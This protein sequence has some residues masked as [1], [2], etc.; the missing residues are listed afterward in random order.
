MQS[1]NRTTAWFPRSDSHPRGHPS[2]SNNCAAS[3]R[4]TAPASLVSL[5]ESTAVRFQGLLSCD[6]AEAPGSAPAM[7]THDGTISF[8]A[9]AYEFS[10]TRREVV[11]IFAM[12]TELEQ[13]EVEASTQTVHYAALSS[14][15]AQQAAAISTMGGAVDGIVSTAVHDALGGG[16]PAPEDACVSLGDAESPETRR[17]GPEYYNEETS[18]CELLAYPCRDGEWESQRAS[19]TSNRNCREWTAC[20]D[21]QFE[22]FAPS[23]TQDRECRDLT[24]ECSGTTPHEFVAPTPTSDRV[25]TDQPPYHGAR[26]KPGKS[27]KFLKDERPDDWAES[28]FYWVQSDQQGSPTRVYCDMVSGG[29]RWH[30]LH[31]H[32]ITHAAP[33]HANPST[34]PRT[35]TPGAPNHSALSRKTPG[36]AGCSGGAGRA[37]QFHAGIPMATV[38]SVPP[39]TRIPGKGPRSSSRTTGSTSSTTHASA[40]HGGMRNKR[41]STGAERTTAA[42]ATSIRRQPTDRATARQTTPK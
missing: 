10:R 37:A 3:I 27:C 41:V 29:G 38:T 32:S 36:A 6:P 14:V 34:P 25:C 30:G 7:S 5:L 8:S 11:D 4:D 31:A 16:A 20:E 39:Q 19:R 26:D 13:M 21:D 1:C 23:L 12:Q 42:A 9:G 24:P 15:V 18:K 2:R 17:W 33:C 28:G 35:R 40:C 22:V